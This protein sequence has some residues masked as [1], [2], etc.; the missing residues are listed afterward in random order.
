MSAFDDDADDK[1]F[2]Q[3]KKTEADNKQAEHDKN[4]ENPEYA[5]KLREE[6]ELYIKAK[7][8]GKT[9]CGLFMVSV[10]ERPDK[11]DGKF[12]CHQHFACNNLSASEGLLKNAAEIAMQ[13]MANNAKQRATAEHGPDHVDKMDKIAELLGDLL[14]KKK[15]GDRGTSRTD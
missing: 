2:R 11:G 12:A 7:E 9:Q 4:Y 8:D 13:A 3:L 15:G 10:V 5:R 1:I 6:L 14:F